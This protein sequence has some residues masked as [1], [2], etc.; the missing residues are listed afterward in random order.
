VAVELNGDMVRHLER[1]RPWLE[2]IPGDAADLVD[3][4]AGAGIKQ[5]D[6]IVS[7]LPWTLLSSEAQR[8]TLDQVVRVLT[9][10]G[11]FTTIT[12]VSAWPFPR[13]VQFRRMLRES[14][15]QFTVLGPVWANVPPALVLSCGEPR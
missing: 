1:S 2:L 14:F 5:V 8:R 13:C 6:A 12:T 11:R 9:P 10:T 4:L 7:A 3:L 15:R